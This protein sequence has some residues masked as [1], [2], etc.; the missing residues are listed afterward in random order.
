MVDVQSY[1]DPDASGPIPTPGGPLWSG[2]STTLA[3]RAIGLFFHLRFFTGAF[4][5]SEF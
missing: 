1:P 4:R 5:L 2:F 3:A